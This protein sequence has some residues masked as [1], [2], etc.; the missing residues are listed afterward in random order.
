MNMLEMY[1]YHAWANKTLLE[2][3]KQ[4]PSEVF[5][6]EIKSVFPSISS[7]ISHVYTVD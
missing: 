7:V 2:R 4:L 5:H 3:L 1:N 6:R